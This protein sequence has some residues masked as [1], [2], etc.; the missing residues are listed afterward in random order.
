MK[1][2]FNATGG[3]GYVAAWYGGSTDFAGSG[4]LERGS[5]S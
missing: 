5:L 4:R 1:Y 3:N 2:F